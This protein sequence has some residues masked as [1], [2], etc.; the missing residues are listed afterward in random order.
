[1][2]E[3]IEPRL[4]SANANKN[5]TNTAFVLFVDLFVGNT[6]NVLC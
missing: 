1:M 3:F 6:L 2:P 5:K 4:L